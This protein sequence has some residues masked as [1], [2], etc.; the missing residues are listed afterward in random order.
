MKAQS[1]I[2]A[3][4]GLAVFPLVEVHAQSMGEI[5]IKNFHE[6]AR[7]GYTRRI[8]EERIGGR[9]DPY[10]TIYSKPHDSYQDQINER[11][12]RRLHQK[13][14]EEEEESYKPRG[15]DPIEVL[16]S[17]SIKDS[18]ANDFDDNFKNRF[19]DDAMPSSGLLFDKAKKKEP[20]RINQW[21]DEE[22]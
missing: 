18:L 11:D 2:I 12:A 19:A 4:I 21:G 6:P 17:R 7:G 13:L 5:M 3:L 16:R 10:E 20:V 8:P 1:I 22:E 9:A 14:R 15:E